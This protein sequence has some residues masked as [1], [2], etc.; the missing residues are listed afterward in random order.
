MEAGDD[1][2][3][4]SASSTV[5]VGP[6]VFEFRIVAEQEGGQHGA[7]V[8]VSAGDVLNPLEKPLPGL[9][10]GT[11]W[12]SAGI[13]DL[14]DGIALGNGGCPVDVAECEVA[15]GVE[16]PGVAG[17]VDWLDAEWELKAV[18]VG[19]VWSGSLRFE[20]KTDAE[21]RAGGKP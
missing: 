18:A 9:D 10:G 20:I 14:D 12:I 19:P 17:I 3:V 2:G 16:I 1:N 21:S 8:A 13:G 11:D 4:V 6:G 15:F 7:E 5:V